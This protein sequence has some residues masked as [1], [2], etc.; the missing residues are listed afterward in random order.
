MPDAIK[1]SLS[2]AKRTQFTSECQN[3]EFLRKINLYI[4]VRVLKKAICY[5]KMDV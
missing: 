3:I 1:V 4:A 5:L 2:G